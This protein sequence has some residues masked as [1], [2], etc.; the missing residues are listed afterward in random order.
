MEPV[1]HKWI[2]IE[3]IGRDLNPIGFGLK[4]PIRRA[5][6]FAIPTIGRLLNETRV[7]KMFEVYEEDNSM[8]V[9]LTPLNYRQEFREIWEEQNPGKEFPWAKRVYN[10]P[11]PEP[12]PAVPQ[13]DPEPIITPLPEVVIPEVVA[14]EVTPDPVVETTTTEETTETPAGEPVVEGSTDEVTV[15]TTTEETTDT[16]SD[17][18][19]TESTEEVQEEVVKAAT[20]TNTNTYNK[21]KQR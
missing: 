1:T 21:R 15:D 18:D 8:R 3:D 9:H 10:V 20:T 2:V 4:S 13:K 19:T 11:T 17:S 16:S 12:T 5:S 7:T 6:K 14:P